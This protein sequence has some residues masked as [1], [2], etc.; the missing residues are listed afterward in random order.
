MVLLKIFAIAYNC[1]RSIAIYLAT[2]VD[3]DNAPIN[4]T[5]PYHKLSISSVGEIVNPTG[6]ARAKAYGTS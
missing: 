2:S 3:D 5:S 1:L 4:R 6:N